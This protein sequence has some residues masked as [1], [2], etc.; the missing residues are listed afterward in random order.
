[1]ENLLHSAA[2]HSVI[3]YQKAS[4]RAMYHWICLVDLTHL[5]AKRVNLGKRRMA[6]NNSHH[7]TRI[8]PEIL[9]NVQCESISDQ[10]SVLRWEVWTK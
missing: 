3:T 4:I 10:S 6:V 7:F 1:M 9:T 8:S 2:K 5:I